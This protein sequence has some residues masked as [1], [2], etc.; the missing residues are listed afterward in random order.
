MVF[1]TSI[2]DKNIKKEINNIVG[3]PFN[4]FQLFKVGAIG[5]VRMEVGAYS[6]LFSKIMS[7][8]KQSVYANISLRPKG[9]IVVI[10]V[11]LSNYSWVIPYHHLSIFKTDLLSIHSQGEYIKLVMPKDHKLTILDKILKHKSD[12]LTN[13]MG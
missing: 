11:R 10:N 1:D 9:I 5:S 3:T 4:V 12:Y 13:S 2:K 8:D 6:Q 7:W